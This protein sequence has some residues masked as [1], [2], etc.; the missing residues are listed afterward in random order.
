MCSLLLNFLQD[1][2]LNWC[3]AVLK[4]LVGLTSKAVW[5]WCFLCGETVN[6]KFYVFNRGRAIQVIYFFLRLF[7]SFKE[8]FYVIIK[9]LRIFPYYPFSM[10]RVSGNVT[11]L[12]SDPDR[13]CPRSFS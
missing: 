7:V 8:L 12:I 3:Y 9:L 11:S 5:V 10:Y 2:V 1:F 13:L 6:Y 4:C